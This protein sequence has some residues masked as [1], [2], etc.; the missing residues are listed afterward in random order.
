LPQTAGR[1]DHGYVLGQRAYRLVI[2]WRLH[3]SS[4]QKERRASPGSGWRPAPDSE[5]R[6]ADICT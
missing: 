5:M 3:G 1:A 4:R 6:G 2:K